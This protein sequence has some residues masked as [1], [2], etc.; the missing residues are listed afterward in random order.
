[1]TSV[2][3]IRRIKLKGILG[4]L[5][6]F[7]ALNAF[8][9]T[10]TYDIVTYTPPQ[11]W[12]RD[13]Q[14]GYI[15]FTA[16]KGNSFCVIGLYKSRPIAA[17]TENEFLTEWNELVNIPSGINSTTVV[18]S[19]QQNGCTVFFGSTSITTKQT[20][21]YKVELTSF[22]ADGNI[23]SAIVKSAGDVFKKESDAF[24][25]SFTLL[26]KEPVITTPVPA[27]V[28]IKPAGNTGK[29][30]K[31]D[32]SGINGVWVGYEKGGW[33]YGATSYNY[34]TNS[35]NYGS[36]YDANVVTIKWRVFWSDGK[37][38]DGMPYGG[39]INFDR[40]DPKNDYAGYYTMDKNMVTSKLDHYASTERLFVFYPPATL[41]FL[42]KFEYVKCQSVDGLRLK[43]TYMPADPTSV[44]YYQ[45]LSKPMPT[46]SFTS[47][48]HFTDANYLD[49]YNNDP[50]L[51]PGSG[52]YD[53]KNFTIT[54][55]FDDGRIVTRSFTPYLNESPA[56]CKV[57]YIASNDIKLVP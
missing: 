14:S 22:A 33:T 5:T 16:S 25:A 3:I 23:I 27:K 39:L 13:T 6:A 8:S 36:K 51:A 52:T 57:F 40:S 19:T 38:Y 55:K 50:A 49:G 12:K 24:L 9:Q 56:K 4:C 21:T 47:D 26:K 7:M 32:N 10:E 42:D 28:E 34:Y 17:I 53:I 54:F 29:E 35:Y 15:S 45:S 18:K 2:P 48:G 1:M 11:S 43:G 44:V 20:G 30:V 31:M 41:K 46:I 37:Y